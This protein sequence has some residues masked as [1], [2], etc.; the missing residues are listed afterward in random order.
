[1][2]FPH[3]NY[4]LFFCQKL[5]QCIS[6]AVIWYGAGIWKTVTRKVTTE[7][8]AE[9]RVHGAICWPTN[10]FRF[11]LTDLGSSVSGT[12]IAGCR[13][14]WST[15]SG[16]RQECVA[17]VPKLWI[18]L[19]SDSFLTACSGEWLCH[20]DWEIKDDQLRSMALTSATAGTAKVRMQITVTWLTCAKHEVRSWLF[21]L[22]CTG[23]RYLHGHASGLVH[24]D[25]GSP[26]E[27]LFDKPPKSG[28]G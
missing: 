22:F 18:K 9:V 4:F 12:L 2:P 16:S 15:A 25:L 23:V 20:W 17:P 13:P 21:C 1:M 5:L 10:F 14:G 26:R 24:A 19:L 8:F 28:C 27:E 6:I 3:H 7:A 11:V